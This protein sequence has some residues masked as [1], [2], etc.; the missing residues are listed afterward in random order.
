MDEETKKLKN[1][2]KETK[3][4]DDVV[5]AESSFG[6]VNLHIDPTLITMNDV[7]QLG[8]QQNA[9]LNRDLFLTLKGKYPSLSDK[10]KDFHIAM[11]LYRL[12]V[13][14]SSLQSDDDTTGITYTRE[15][16]EVDLSDKLWTD[17]VFNSKGIGNRT[18]A[19]RVWGRTNDA[20]YLAFCRQ[21]RNLSYGGRP[22][23]AGIPAGYHYLCADFLTGAGLTDL[24]C[25]V[26][27]QAKEQLL[28]KRGADEVVVTNVRQLGKFNTR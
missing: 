13:K 21:N 2:N 22:L 9:A 18:N 24:E 8:T 11:M 4:G 5:A 26:Y 20:L 14:S 28:K 10:D 12:A 15:G 19:L 27:I 1:K 17:V 3:E 7:R 25:A 6:S 16:V 23:D